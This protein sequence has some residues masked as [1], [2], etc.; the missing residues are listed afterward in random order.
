VLSVR[1]DQAL[2]LEDIRLRLRSYVLSDIHQRLPV[3]ATVITTGQEKQ[4][5]RNKDNGAYEF[6]GFTI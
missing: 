3:A 5:N 2:G 4:A 6:H 1:Q